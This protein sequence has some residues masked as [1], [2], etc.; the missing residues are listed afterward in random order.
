[1]SVV[2]VRVPV[3][4][5]TWPKADM[6]AVTLDGKILVNAQALEGVDIAELVRKKN[7]FGGV[8]LDPNEIR[9]LGERI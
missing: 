6:F 4:F 1:M 8:E 2:R 3:R 5:M 9:Q 7:V